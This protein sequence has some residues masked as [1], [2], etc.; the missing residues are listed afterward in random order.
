MVNIWQC[1]ERSRTRSRMFNQQLTCLQFSVDGGHLAVGSLR[2]SLYVMDPS[3]LCDITTGQTTLKS[4]QIMD[5]KY[6]PNNRFLAVALHC[7]SLQIFEVDD[8]YSSRA[9]LRGHLFPLKNL[10]WDQSSRFIRTTSSGCELIFW[11]CTS[12]T[13]VRDLGQVRDL[14]W[15]TYHI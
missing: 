1:E 4:S 15:Q 11:D 8:G 14:N 3:T 5:V 9:I 10:D 12:K 2:G 13:R 6:S 7:R